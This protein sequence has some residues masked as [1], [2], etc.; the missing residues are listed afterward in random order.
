M[1]P[2]FLVHH[3]ARRG[4]RYP[5]SSLSALHDCLEAGARFVEIDVTPLADGDFALLH[6]ARLDIATEGNGPVQAATAAQL[7]GLRLRWRG[8]L[9]DE[10]GGTL[11]DAV[12]LAL[13]YSSLVEL[14]FDLKVHM[15]LTDATLQSLARL[16]APLGPHVRVSSTS[17][18]AIRHLLM[19]APGLALGFDP[20]R[21]LDVEPGPS[22]TT[23]QYLCHAGAYGYL[24][25]HPLAADR[26]GEPCEYL[27]TRSDVLWAMVPAP[28]WYVRATLLARMLDDGFDWI[29]D[30]H[31]R[32]ARVATWTLN[33]DQPHHR[34]L[35]ARLVE[36]GVDRII[37]DNAAG[38]AA[39]LGASVAF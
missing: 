38:M 32:G 30:L 6:D 17:D 29:A 25:D 12:S 15:P 37:T 35:A 3:A 16:V 9:T 28:V 34:T 26:W 27:K 33:P 13:N 14:Q 22:P 31:R 19:L 11:S 7:R 10:C 36:L 5:P 18:R 23:S 24:D 1:A 4:N 20:L 39:V 8:V 2:T 21:H